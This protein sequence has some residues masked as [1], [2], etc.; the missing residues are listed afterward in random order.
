MTKPTKPT[1]DPKP[2]PMD[3]KLDPQTEAPKT[4]P[5]DHPC[6]FP[7]AAEWEFDPVGRYWAR[8]LM[9]GRG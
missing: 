7:D 6:P 8:R 2:M 5:E 1:R 4:A 3:S 9:G